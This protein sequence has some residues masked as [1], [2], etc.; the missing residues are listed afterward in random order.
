[1]RRILK[2][3]FPRIPLLFVWTFLTMEL[4]GRE[5]LMALAYPAY[6]DGEIR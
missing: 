4:S 3:E 6:E 1:M 2:R 5:K